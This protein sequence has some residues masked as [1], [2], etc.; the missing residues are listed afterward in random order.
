MTTPAT[1]TRRT[2]PPWV[3][4]GVVFTLPAVSLPSLLVVRRVFPGR[5]LATVAVVV[6]LVGVAS[7]VVVAAGGSWAA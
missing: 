4:V 2:A 7:A 5:L 1:T 3:L 6:V